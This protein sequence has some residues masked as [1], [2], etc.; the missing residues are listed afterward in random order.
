MYY[1]I[2][3]TIYIFCYNYICFYLLLFLNL[4]GYLTYII[5]RQQVF[6]SLFIFCAYQIILISPWYK[7]IV[8]NIL[9]CTALNYFN[10]CKI[11]FFLS[12]LGFWAGRDQ[13][14][15]LVLQPFQIVIII[16]FICHIT[17]ITLYCYNYIFFLY[18]YIHNVY[19]YI[20]IYIYIMCVSI[21]IYNVCIYIYIYIICV[22]AAPHK[23]PTVRPPAP[24]HENYSS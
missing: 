15:L 22:S 24:Y 12:Y 10:K 2:Y 13:M 11:F 17:F 4:W 19:I 3:F 18:I 21:Y 7:I 16:F 20:Y 23:T 14:N 9:E 5:S 6:R 8:V 1:N